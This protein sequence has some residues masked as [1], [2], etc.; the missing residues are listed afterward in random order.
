[1]ER[2][3]RAGRGRR[4]SRTTI[5]PTARGPTAPTAPALALA[6][7]LAATTTR[8]AMSPLAL[9]LAL[10]LWALGA[11]RMVLASGTPLLGRIRVALAAVGRPAP[12]PAPTA[13]APPSSTPPGVGY[14]KGLHILLPVMLTELRT[15]KEHKSPI[16]RIAPRNVVEE[17]CRRVVSMSR[18]CV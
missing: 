11:W 5:A 2:L 16:S 18:V 1:M 14:T 9:A 7:T 8:L 6:V 4:G 10:P 13:P 17:R 12:A 3:R 15:S